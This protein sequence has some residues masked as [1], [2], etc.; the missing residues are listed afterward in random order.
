[1]HYLDTGDIFAGYK[2]I[3]MCGKGASGVVYLAED[4]VGRKVVLKIVESFLYSEREL[5]G[6]RNYMMISGDHQGLLRIYHIGKEDNRIYYTM[7]AA[8]NILDNGNYLPA[9]LGNRFRLNERFTPE[10]AVDIMRELLAGLKF[11]HQ[12]NL[13][14]RDIKPD[15]IIFVGGR[16]KLS[17]PG[18]VAKAGA[19]VTFAGTIG[20][21]P[22]E[23]FD[24]EMKPSPATDIYAIGKVFYCMTTGYSP[25]QYPQL[26]MDMRVEV[27]RQ[28]YPALNRMCNRNPSKRFKDVDELLKNLP[29]KMEPPNFFERTR[30][31]FRIWKQLN[32]ECYRRIIFVIIFFTVLAAAALCFS[33]VY[34][35]RQEK[36]ALLQ[37]AETEK[38]LALNSSRREMLDFQLQIYFPEIY[39]VFQ[40]K[41]GA[42]NE[43]YGKNNYS[44]SS[45]LSRELWDLLDFT[46]RKNM[47]EIP[48]KSGVF[49]AD[50][51][52]A[53]AAHSFL[54]TPIAEY[55]DKEISTDFRK[56]LKAHE[57]RLYPHWSGVRCG[58]EW[59]NI[60]N[61]YA[62]M[63]F[64]PAGAVRM[65]HSGEVVK[66]PY[67]FWISQKEMVHEQFTRILN[68]APQLSPFSNTPIERCIWNDV[69]FFCYIKTLDWRDSGV[70][71]P[72][73]IVRPPT[74]E[75]WEYAAKNA[76]LGK[77][78]T[79]FEKRTFFKKNS[80][81]RTHPS[82]A[83]LPNKL[84]LYD[85]Y[86][87]VR[88][89]AVLK[90]V[91]DGAQNSVVTRGGSFMTAA[92]K[93][94]YGRIFQLK[95]Q[96]IPYDAGFRIVFAPGTLDFFDKHF[97][98]TDNAGFFRDRGKV[99]EAF[100]GN[101]GSLDWEKSRKLCSLLGGRL[102][103]FED[104]AQ[105]ELI[106]KKIT[107]AGLWQTCIGGKK[108]DGKWHWLHSGKEINFGSWQKSR[109][110][111]KDDRLAFYSKYL[112][113]V[114][115]NAVGV[116]LCEWDEK[117]FE[118]RNEQLKTL[119]KLPFESDRFVY[120]D[121]MYIL[122]NCNLLWYTA[123]RICET[124][125]GNLA[126]LDTPELQEFVKKRVAEKTQRQ[127][128]LGGYAKRNDF[129]WLS[130]KKAEITL[131]KDKDSPIPTQNRNFIA[132]KDG[133]FYNCQYGQSFL[134]E[135]PASSFSAASL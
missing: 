1:M 82:G 134:A 45:R 52:A 46:A 113:P 59:I 66:I 43:A 25:G 44:E 106:N 13:I 99:F 18:L 53:G 104:Q 80:G 48:G 14:H 23:A 121:K 51:N 60:Q 68:I 91:E 4:P 72:G 17:D 21:I 93:Q 101:L 12:A 77:D 26:P 31:R 92:E 127:V 131:K 125:G 119:K 110:N 54:D 94:C 34:Q 32:R 6:L 116:F 112:S 62:P 15:N 39:P 20:F 135:F 132:L 122:F 9:T 87:N 83:L 107:L 27:C 76:W 130:G 85:I 96:N 88:E 114:K 41:F 28:L 120:K 49:K 7:E 55:L 97:Y 42:L 19:S 40:Q 61:Y 89:M 115:D 78:D 35:E 102:A 118:K 70:L 58:V 79:P 84:G 10:E 24:Q 29:E 74:E 3:A 75:E 95:M 129:F 69:L 47:P 117:D 126:S 90:N 108:I 103:E 36:L 30:E 5:D 8:D 22:P 65:D 124:L 73:Y 57:D 38:F 133:T 50:F 98:R 33:K 71:P 100:G 105:L 11:M 67:H 86:G 109:N 2:I 111:E 123:Q 16:A 56:K 64:V 128:L 63:S 37:K 81:N